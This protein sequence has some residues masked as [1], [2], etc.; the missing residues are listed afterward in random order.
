MLLLEEVYMAKGVMMKKF[1]VLACILSILVSAAVLVGCGG[2]GSS[3]QTPEK[4]AQA[5]FAAMQK[6][7]ANTTWNLMS[8]DSQKKIGTKAAW[9]ASS[10]EST[11]LMKFTVGNVTVNG[12]KATAKVT[13]TVSGKT[14]TQTIPLVK[15]NGVWKV[16]II[17]AMNQ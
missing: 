17:G 12:N 4:A 6:V 3:S 13:G 16:D 1:V 5:F 14:T 11:S 10:K 15:E 9:V 2:G 7:D 8:A